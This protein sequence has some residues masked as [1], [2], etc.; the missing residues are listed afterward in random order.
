LKRS[1]ILAI[2]LAAAASMVLPL[3]AAPAV[4][5]PKTQA[6]AT[7]KP[8]KRMGIVFNFMN[9]LSGVLPYYD[10]YQFGAGGKI[11]LDESMVVR[12]L[13]G[14][15]SFAPT[16]GDAETLVSLGAGIEFHGAGARMSPYCGVVAGVGLD[17]S[18]GVTETSLYLGGIG[19]A[20]LRLLDNLSLF[21]EYQLKLIVGPSGTI[22]ALADIGAPAS[23]AAFG[24]ILYF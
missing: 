7:A 19:G 9:P 21:G 22:V 5:A 13:A 4:A 2:T 10:G 18:A 12:A 16:A 8:A 15:Y 20:E 24:V 11:W 17:V 23:G 14:L 1:V 6:A 3:S